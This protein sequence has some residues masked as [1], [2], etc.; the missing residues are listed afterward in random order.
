MNRRTILLLLFCAGIVVSLFGCG[1]KHHDAYKE[2]DC[3]YEIKP[4]EV[5]NLLLSEEDFWI[6][7][8]NS[9]DQTCID[10]QWQIDKYLTSNSKTILYMDTACE[11]ES[12]I[13]ALAEIW[14]QLGF[15][16]EEEIKAVLH[17]SNGYRISYFAVDDTDGLKR[18]K[19]TYK[20]EQ[21][22]ANDHII[23]LSVNDFF[24]KMQNGEEMWVYIGRPR[25]YNCRVRYRSVV[26]VLSNC[27]KDIYYILSDVDILTEEESTL[28]FDFF[29]END[30]IEVP[31]VVHI[32]DGEVKK[33]YA[34]SYDEEYT[35]F[36][37]D[38]ANE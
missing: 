12:E 13:E 1:T 38:I 9:S 21:V 37:T 2:S 24:E 32:K 6:F 26:K 18:F 11:E 30:E 29:G 10:A 7:I 28:L 35:A 20:G 8:G 23:R 3:I 31:L 14:E 16:E 27:N 34:I 15:E 5:R 22:T 19:D 33:N 36:E 4:S 25:C 17:L